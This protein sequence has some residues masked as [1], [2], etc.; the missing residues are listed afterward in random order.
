M[1]GRNPAVPDSARKGWHR[2]P[3][4]ARGRG[5]YRPFAQM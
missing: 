3:R 4:A 5:D 2:L 1:D